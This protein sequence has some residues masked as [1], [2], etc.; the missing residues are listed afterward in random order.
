[1][2]YM[3]PNNGAQTLNLQKPLAG[4]NATALGIASLTFNRDPLTTDDSSTGMGVGSVVFNNT[5]GQLRTWFCRDATVGAAK[6]VFDG[7]DY[8]NGG[9]NPPI[10]ITQFGGAASA[11]MAEEGNINRIVNS[12]GVQPAS[13]AADIVLAVY[14]L[15]AA[16]FDQAGRG[17]NFQACGSTAS[18][19]T[20][21]ARQDRI[22]GHDR[23]RWVCRRWRHSN[24]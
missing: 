7:A 13:T 22:R 9:T 20:L 12:T 14:T 21:Q 5:A 16:A 24:C 4:G 11:Q 1:M 18:N 19:T 17:L 15:P 3:D 10:E 2:Q 8:A 23:G 6:W